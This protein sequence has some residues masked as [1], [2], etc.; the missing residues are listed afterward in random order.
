MKK[1]LITLLSLLIM[2]LLLVTPAFSQNKKSDVDNVKVDQK[3]YPVPGIQVA[4]DIIQPGMRMTDIFGL[5]G[6]PDK[7]WAMRSKSDPKKDYVKMDYFTYGMAVDINNNTNDVHGILLQENNPSVKLMN[8]PFRIGQDQGAITATWGQPES[9]VNG[10]LNYW[11]RGVYF[12]IGQGG[13]ISYM[14]MALP[15]EFKDEK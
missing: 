1:H 10:V 12:G 15:G 4:G 13:K 3:K 2:I 11:R 6:P 8:C 14:F 9:V 7:I 5:L